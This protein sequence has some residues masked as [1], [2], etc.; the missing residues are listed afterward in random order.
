MYDFDFNDTSELL[1]ECINLLNNND[2]DTSIPKLQQLLDE[3][4]IFKKYVGSVAP[5]AETIQTVEAMLAE[6]EK[7]E[8]SED[9]PREDVPLTPNQKLAILNTHMI[10]LQSEIDKV[11][12][13]ISESTQ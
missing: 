4:N 12:Q 3:I 1:T 8:I 5:S 2:T 9:Q 6:N 7:R 13:K 10:K 11:Q